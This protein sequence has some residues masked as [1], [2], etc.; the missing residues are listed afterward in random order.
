MKRGE[1]VPR[2]KVDPGALVSTEPFQAGRK[3]V[4]GEAKKI[5]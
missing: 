1:R 5:L 3:G 2:D 4:K